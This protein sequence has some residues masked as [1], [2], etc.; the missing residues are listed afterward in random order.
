MDNLLNITLFE[1]NLQNFENLLK[2][3]NATS[4]YKSV[5]FYPYQYTSL[6][7]ETLFFPTTIYYS[8][9]AILSSQTLSY[10]GVF[11]I[12][13]ALNFFSFF[14]L[15]KVLKFSFFNSILG[16]ILYTSGHFF[17]IQYVHIQNQ[18]AFGFPI[19]FALITQFIESKK[20]IYLY[21]IT[22]TLILQFFSCTYF[23]VYLLYFSFLIYF[24]TFFQKE[25]LK[26]FSISHIHNSLKRNG[27]W[28]FTLAIVSFVIFVFFV[29]GWFVYTN[30][31]LYPKRE[32]IENVFYSNTLLSIFNL[33]AT[34][35]TYDSYAPF[36]VTHNSVHLGYVTFATIL[37]SFLYINKLKAIVKLY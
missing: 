19:L 21:F 13:S 17:A 15:T 4:I 32:L 25:D 18:F 9:K 35:S 20:S 8:L 34:A 5:G 11:F 27:F 14:Y 2:G 33:T 12:S 22:I 26:T 16:S 30:L 23:G 24:I 6:F 29:Y 37:I 36:G 31:E 1:K 10:N 28:K 7:T 3:G